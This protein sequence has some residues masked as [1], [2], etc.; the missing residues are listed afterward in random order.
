MKII[1]IN[2]CIV[3]VWQLKDSKNLCKDHYRYG[4]E[5]D[6]HPCWILNEL[7]LN[8]KKPAWYEVIH[9][10]A[11][12]FG[13]YVSELMI[14]LKMSDNSM[15]SEKHDDDQKVSK[16]VVNMVDTG[17]SKLLHRNDMIV[18]WPWVDAVEKTLPNKPI[19]P[20][21]ALLD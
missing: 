19:I 6:C 10:L 5:K 15:E 7:N 14:S 17:R 21:T 18:I 12:L 11:N 9:C 8:G 1:R 13:K 2:L 4:K 3:L 20:E 16:E